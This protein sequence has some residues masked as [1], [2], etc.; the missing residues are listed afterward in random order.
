MDY[1][2]LNLRSGNVLT[3]AHM[4]H[5]E[6]GIDSVT[7]E[8]AKIKTAKIILR[9]DTNENWANANTILLKGEPAIEFDENNVAKVKIG[10][11]VTAWKDLPYLVTETVTDEEEA[12]FDDLVDRI[13]TLETSVGDF[14]VRLTEVET[15]V[16]AAMTVSEE[17]LVK[18]ELLRAKIDSETE[19]RNEAIAA[20]E[21]KIKENATAIKDLDAEVENVK[22]AQN[23]QQM[24]IDAAN[25]RVDT[26]VAGFTDNAEFDNAE[27]LDIRAGYNGVTY[28]SA[29][30]AVRQIGYDLNELSSNLEG[31]LGKDLVDGLLYEGNQLYLTANGEI[32][33]DPVTIV[34]GSGGSGGSQTYTI[35]LSDLLGSRVLTVTK[36]EK[37][38]LKFNYRSVDEDGFDD[39]TGIG[40]IFTDKGQITTVIQQGDNTFDITPYLQNGANN[41]AIQ[42]ENSEGS[43]KK[44]TYTVTVMVLSVTTTSPKMALY[45]GRVSFPYTVTG[46]GAKTV[47]FLMDGYQ[48]AKE[49]VTT[50]GIGRVLTLPD[51]IT[52]G[53]HILQI[54]AEVSNGLTDIIKSNILEV[55]MLYYSPIT[56]TQSILLMYNGPKEVEQG[57]TLTFPYMVYDPIQQLSDIVLNIYNEDGSL[58]DKPYEISVNRQPQQWSTQDYPAGKITF[59]IVCKDVRVSQTIEV[60]PTSFDKKIITDGCVLN[61]EAKGRSNNESNPESWEYKGVTAEFSG[62]GWTNVDGWVSNN[63]QTA[64]RF[65]PGNSMKI[66]YKPFDTDLRANGFTLEAEFETHNVRDYDSIIASSIDD[67]RGFVIKSQAAQLSSVQATVSAQF[68]EDSRIRV[69]FVVEPRSLNKFVYIYINGIMSKVIQYL[70]DDNF[71]Q[72]TPISISIGAESCGL[73]LYSLRIYNRSFTRYEQL[74]NFICDRPTLAERIEA[75]KRNDILD[76]TNSIT[77]NTLPKTIPYIILECEELPQYKGDKKKDKSVT[78]IDPMN[79]NR[80]FTAKGVQFDVQGTSSAGY[81]I[82]NY[83]VSLKK[84]LTYTASGNAAEG[85]PILEGGL[86]GSTICLKADFASSEQANNVMLVDYYEQLSPYLNPAQYYEDENGNKVPT[87]VR[88]AV[89]GF[90]C[91]VFWKNTKDNTTTFIGKY[92]FND[93]KSNENVFGFDKEKYPKCECWEFLNNDS[94]RVLFQESEYEREVTVTNP[95]GTSET[96]PAW[97]DDFEARFPD[98]DDPYRDYT[99]FKRM[100]DWVVST[101][102]ELVGTEEEKTTRLQKFKNEFEQYFIKEAMLFYY[103]FTEIFVLADSRAKNLFLTTFDGEHWFPIPYDMDTAI[104]IDNTGNLLFEYDA[105]DT[106]IVNGA[107][108]FSGQASILWKNVRDAFGAELKT[109]YSNLRSDAAKPFN[110]TEIRDKMKNHQSVWPEALWNEDQTIK[111]INATLAGE[112]DEEGNIISHLPKLQGSKES[113]R[114]WWLYNGFKYRDSKYQTGDATKNYIFLRLFAPGNIFVTPYSHIWPAAKYGGNSAVVTV[115]GKKNETYELVNPVSQP[116]NLETWIYSADRISKIGDLSGFKIGDAQFQAAT[117]LQEIILGSD[118]EGYENPNLFNLSVGTNELLT[119]VNVQNCTNAAFQTID[120]SACHGLETILANG[121]A[122]TGLALP[123]GGH[124]KTLKLPGSFTTLTI[125]NQKNIEELTLESQE[126]LRFLRIENSPNLPIEELVNNSPKL[127]RVRLTDIEWEASD[128]ASLKKTIDRLKTCKGFETDGTNIDEPTVTGRVHVEEISLEEIKEINQ[129]FP[130]LVV[131]VNGVA[132][133]FVNYINWNRDPLYSYLATEGSEA[134]DPV[135]LGYID[136]PVHESIDDRSKHTYIGWT[137]IPENII[138]PC[139][140]TAQYASEYLV[141]FYDGPNGNVLEGGEQWVAEN[142]SAIDPVENGHASAPTKEPTVESRFIFSGWNTNFTKVTSPLDCYPVFQ[143]V[144]QRYLCTFHDDSGNVLGEI[145]IQYGHFAVLPPEIDT[146]QIDKI[147]GGEPSEYYEFTGWT[148]D[149]DTT[150]ILKDTNFYPRFTFNG[151]IEDSWEDIAL[152]CKNGDVSK[153]DLGGV[154]RMPITVNYNNEKIQMDVEM[155]IVGKDHDI[156]QT[157]SVEYNQNKGTAA[158]TFMSKNLIPI[159]MSFLNSI[160]EEYAGFVGQN[161]M[162]WEKCPVRKE[163][164]N[165]TIFVLPTEVKNNIKTVKKASD[166]GYP[167]QGDGNINDIR[168][169]NYTYDNMWIPSI[170]EMNAIHNNAIAEQG[171]PYRL[172]TDN[173]SRIKKVNEESEA[174]WTRSTPAWYDQYIAI[175]KEGG[176]QGKYGNSISSTVYICFGFCL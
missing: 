61:F 15:G 126:N 118:A 50:S 55:G 69:T 49:T 160:D 5:I 171:S 112:R 71:T 37:C 24:K 98:L 103:L 153:Y 119:L 6:E 173:E 79:S 70:D 32:I 127:E 22:D 10:D 146:E 94:T 105:E 67:G 162:G 97:W 19:E 57:A 100:T 82:K 114:D 78:F 43:R 48:I 150:Q 12:V 159:K 125:Q 41:I 35:T 75:D 3:A 148:P 59:E 92:N 21:N 30:A 83:K 124:L 28:T 166:L 64:L 167:R 1:K 81:P 144:A 99:Q 129:N 109:M 142:E 169:L 135:E 151:Y 65:L 53:A 90:P 141:R 120:L 122:L 74:N 27:L 108:V 66:D 152:A 115:K 51:N 26:L 88:T 87:S 139:T 39:G 174:Y 165:P 131:V 76:E 136:T 156:L 56:T 93:D 52:D 68:K 172:F 36:D 2:E 9:N 107:T 123:N 60:A 157:A 45:S 18:I 137:K 47:Y 110:Y 101:N 149:L 42:V 17:A 145:D 7:E 155:E 72:N 4:A 31:A 86:E 176:T 63:G 95:D 62:F 33:S 111:Y 58:Y 164:N 158:L 116:N 29:G 132:Y 121:S 11:G 106:D 161:V 25:A 128:A 175:T 117:K 13:V 140:I 73:D 96:Y 104:G 133:Y 130:D 134:F 102:R 89:R 40:H 38:V 170:T 80:N 14:D 8:V 168:K 147:I 113:Q 163:L 84:G 91:V 85:F 54:Y 44:L 16:T 23:T 154:V 143:E 77:L 138:K 20:V 46:S 34:G